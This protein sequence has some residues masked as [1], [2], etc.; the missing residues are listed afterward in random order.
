MS[1]GV[2]GLWLGTESQGYAGLACCPWPPDC[3]SIQPV[4]SSLAYA[5][6]HKA[7]CE[8]D[9]SLKLTYLG[10]KQTLPTPPPPP[11]SSKLTP[12]QA[13]VQP[14]LC[15]SFTFDAGHTAPA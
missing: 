2:L 7:E 13:F 9:S 6:S 11:P 8:G 12:R 10:W 15:L 3:P 4:S 14:V 1:T 5:V